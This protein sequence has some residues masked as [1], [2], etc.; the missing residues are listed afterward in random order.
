MGDHLLHLLV[1][2]YGDV[3]HSTAVDAAQV[4]LRLAQTVDVE[5]SSH[6]LDDAGVVGIHELELLAGCRGEHRYLAIDVG[7]GVGSIEGDIDLLVVGKLL[8]VV[9]DHEGVLALH[10]G[11]GQGRYADGGGAA[12]HQDGSLGF[13]AVGDGVDVAR[14]ADGGIAQGKDRLADGAIHFGLEAEVGAVLG[15]T[16]EGVA[17]IGLG[18]VLEDGDLL[19]GLI[20]GDGEVLYLSGEC[21]GCHYECA[22]TCIL[23]HG[24]AVGGAACQLDNRS[25]T[26]S[27]VAELLLGRGGKHLDIALEPG[28]HVG[29]GVGHVGS[30]HAIDEGDVLG[31]VIEGDGELG[32]H[33]G[34][35]D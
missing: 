9:V 2:H 34:V 18:S 3:G 14:R 15:M 10:L 26:C 21:G 8:T 29:A 16:M 30:L 35:G 22:F 24:V 5:L 11:I 28:I 1:Y 31:Q 6:H 4:E 33:L 32:L 27:R 25:G 17:H 19:D 23:H 13:L 12:A 20:H 7:C